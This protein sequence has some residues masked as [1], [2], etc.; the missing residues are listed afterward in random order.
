MTRF[1]EV[2]V[3]FRLCLKLPCAWGSVI[4]RLAVFL[5]AMVAPQIIIKYCMFA[6]PG[7]WSKH[8]IFLLFTY[9]LRSP[10]KPQQ[11]QMMMKNVFNVHSGFLF[12]FFKLFTKCCTQYFV[13]LPGLGATQGS[14]RFSV[15][16]SHSYSKSL[17]LLNYQ[18]IQY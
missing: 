17:R 9:F 1:D 2:T 18:K 7:M 11:L 15:I 14:F 4:N 12:L 10:L 6:L 16:F 3:A 5:R 8:R 13:A